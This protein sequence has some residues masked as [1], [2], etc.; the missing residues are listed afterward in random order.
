[1]PRRDPNVIE[2]NQITKSYGLI[3]A[4]RGIDLTARQGEILGLLGPNGAGKTT[5]MKILTCFTPPSS[6]AFKVGGLDGITNPL[7]V[8]SLTGYMPEHNPLY[9]EMAVSGFLGFIARAK[10]LTG[11]S[12]RDN[13]KRVIA[14]CGLEKV[15]HRI[16]KHL[17]KGYRQRVGLAQAMIGNP[18]VLILDE[19]TI[20][21]DPGQVVEMRRL[22]KEMGERKTVILSSHILSEVSQ[23]CDRVV[24]IHQGKILAQDPPKTLIKQLA[25]SLE[26]GLEIR[27]EPQLVMKTLQKVRGVRSVVKGEGN[28]RFKAEVDRDE[29]VRSNIARALLEGGCDLL[30]MRVEEMELEEIFLHIVAHEEGKRQS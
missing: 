12:H 19:P 15:K 22:I 9:L 27:G 21:L 17:S 7:S 16:I 1:M 29:E 11:S 25:Q 30:E 10:S 3:K 14:Q 2:M 6:G 13:V 8:R 26:V 24:I 20:G 18:L 28:N 5:I 23:I 4:L